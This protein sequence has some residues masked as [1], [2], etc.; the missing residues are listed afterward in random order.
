MSHPFRVHP[1]RS[2]SANTAV[3]IVPSIGCIGVFGIRFYAH[4]LKWATFEKPEKLSF[5]KPEQPKREMQAHG[6]KIIE[7]RKKNPW[8][9][10]KTILVSCIAAC[11]SCHF[12]HFILASHSFG[13]I[14]QLGFNTSNDIAWQT[15]GEGEQIQGDEGR[16][17]ERRSKCNRSQYIGL[18]VMHDQKRNWKIE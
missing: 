14:G 16:W 11:N 6:M 18:D 8:S 5:E 12:M 13:S 15:K 4:S 7:R 9:L 2:E 3:S 10:N 17:G 1:S